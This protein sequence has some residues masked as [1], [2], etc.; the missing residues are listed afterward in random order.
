[1]DQTNT[2][3]SI[4]I[5][6]I[7]ILVAGSSLTAIH[8]LSAD[9]TNRSHIN[10][11]TN[12]IS[13]PRQQQPV[14]QNAAISPSNE[15]NGRRGDVGD[16]GISSDISVSGNVSADSNIG[17]SGEVEE[18]VMQQQQQLQEQQQAV[19]ISAVCGQVV[20]GVVNL[21]AN[22]NCSSGD[23]IIVG[24]PNT[25]INMNGF[26]ITGPGQDSSKVAIM[27][28]NV[29]NV[30]VNGP[31]S[32]SNF[33]AGVL[34][35]GANGFKISSVIL[36]NNQIGTFMTGADNAQVQQNII[37]GNSIGVA[38]H[39]STGASIDSNLMNGNL[40]AG[41]TFVNIQQSSVG[42][43]NVVGSQNGVFLDGQSKQNTISANNVLE[44]V[45]DLNNA[46]GLPTN[47][48][49]N[50]YVDNS[51]DTSNPSGLCIGK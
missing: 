22:H 29:D 16:V 19:P 44:N 28:P 4:L 7:G 30:V 27:V 51:C 47:I 17:V 5:V 1:M 6:M 31:G 14:I 8:M 11:N 32:L 42:M 26:S 34:L 48:N 35:T 10:D 24:G 25:V 3:R 15:G 40:L 37:Q 43:N 41:I 33:Q 18:F 49:A 50:Q 36:S 23:G 38:S 39:S 45:I 21:T 20:S 2:T 12:N 46:N 9:S 13:P